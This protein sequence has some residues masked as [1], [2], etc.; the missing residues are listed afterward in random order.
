MHMFKV[1][2]YLTLLMSLTASMV[3]Y[4]P[5]AKADSKSWLMGWSNSHWENQEHRPYLM[6]PAN[7]HNRQWDM[8]N[9]HDNG[10]TP[11]QWTENSKGLPTI[12]GFFRAGILHKRKVEN[13]TPVLVVG[14]NFYKLSVYDRRRVAEMVD[15]V[16]EV[17][18][19]SAGFYQLKDPEFKEIIG[20]YDS[21]GL[22]LR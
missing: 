21:H 2:Q 12:E 15:Y 3:F 18:K 6:P 11:G 14:P 20:Y 4:M 10:W 13:D 1:A 19:S 16:Y 5:C 7:G 9:W 22:R 17:T 8:K